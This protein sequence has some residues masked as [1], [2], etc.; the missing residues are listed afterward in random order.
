[1]AHDAI[2]AG[3]GNGQ[4]ALVV[5]EIIAQLTVDTAV[6]RSLRFFFLHLGNLTLMTAFLHLGLALCSLTLGLRL[7]G[8]TFGALALSGITAGS[9]TGSTL[10]TGLTL[11]GFGNASLV[12]AGSSLG[13]SFLARQ[14][15]GSLLLGSSL[16]GSLLAGF[17]GSAGTGLGHLLG[18]QPVD[19]GVQFLVFL[20]LVVDDALYGLL[21]FLQRGHHLLLFGL[22]GLQ[23]VVLLLVFTQQGVLISSFLLQLILL[24]RNLLL[25]GLHQFALSTLESGIFPHKAQTAVHLTEVLGREDE[26]QLVL[27][28]A[29]AGHVAQA[30]HVFLLALVQLLFQRGELC[31]QQ[32]DVSFDMGYFALNTLYALL[33]LINLAV[34]DQQV[35]E[36]L[37]HVGLVGLEQS[38]LFL[39]FFLNLRALVL[40]SAYFGIGID[41]RAL[42]FGCRLGSLAFPGSGA[43]GGLSLFA[44]T[45]RCCLLLLG[46]H[47]GTGRLLRDRSLLRRGLPALLCACRHHQQQSNQYG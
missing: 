26:H 34:D 40:Q 31:L 39:Y 44:A 13:G 27:H 11:A 7:T 2:L 12:F 35:A 36:P 16:G 23:L 19:G 43:L 38:F 24:G 17:F 6:E 10:G 14:F 33:P 42:A 32:V 20:A 30:F 25:L 9:L 18:N 28:I 37:L 15:L 41:G 21:L 46:R 3:D 8:L 1:M 22:L 47:S 5:H 4:P 45:G 29:V